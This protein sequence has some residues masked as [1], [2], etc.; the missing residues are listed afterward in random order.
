MVLFSIK[1][2]KTD[3]RNRLVVI[4]YANIK[5]FVYFFKGEFFN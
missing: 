3:E 1:V 2:T 4:L 5:M